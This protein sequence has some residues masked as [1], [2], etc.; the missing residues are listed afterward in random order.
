MGIDDADIAGCE[1]HASSW[2]DPADHHPFGHL[3]H[4]LNHLLIDLTSNGSAAR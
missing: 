3:G 2:S 1:G 4:H